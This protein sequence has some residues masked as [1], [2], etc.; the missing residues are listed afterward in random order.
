VL[1]SR[2]SV[3][4]EET[5]LEN[6]CLCGVLNGRVRNTNGFSGISIYVDFSV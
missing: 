5:E 2:T 3:F 1:S 4:L 6:A